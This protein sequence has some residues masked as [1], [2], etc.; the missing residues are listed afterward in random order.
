MRYE[1]SLRG[2]V[3]KWG[4]FLDLEMYGMVASEVE[5]TLSE[6]GAPPQAE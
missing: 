4:E 6:T 5:R 3:L 1:G 2:H